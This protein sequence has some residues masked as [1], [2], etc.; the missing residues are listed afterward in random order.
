MIIVDVFL[1]IDIVIEFVGVILA[2]IVVADDVVYV[3]FFNVVVLEA[4]IT[5]LIYIFVVTEV[6]VINIVVTSN[7][8]IVMNNGHLYRPIIALLQS[9]FMVSFICIHN[10]FCENAMLTS[11]KF[12][13]VRP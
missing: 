7:I 9:R 6:D 5:V 13:Y 2:G 12:S 4:F 1:S 3:V 11:V 8:I 10:D